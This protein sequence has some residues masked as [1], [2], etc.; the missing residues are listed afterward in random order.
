VLGRVGRLIQFRQMSSMAMLNQQLVQV[1][2]LLAGIIH[3]I[4]GPLAVIK[5]SA[6]VLKMNGPG[7]GEDSPWVESIL[8]NAQVLQVRLNHLLATVRNA[9][10]PAETIDVPSLLRES[11]DLFVKGLPAHD[12]QIQVETICI[13]PVPSIQADPGRLMQVIF[14]LLGNA[15]QALAGSMHGGRIVVRIGTA[16]VDSRP[17][18]TVEVIDNGPGIPAAY[19]DRIFEPFFTTREGGTGYGL[20]LASEILKEQ[21]G[22]LEARNNPQGGATFTVWLSADESPVSEDERGENPQ[23]P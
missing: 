11:I 14:N 6:E 9:A 10:S 5:G 4:R 20:Y 2:R 23:S 12:R 17:W 3:E 19:I 1:G 16:E 15:H 7:E 21:S 22:R 18:V 8:R 13:Q